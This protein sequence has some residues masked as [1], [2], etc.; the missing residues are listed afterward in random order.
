MAGSPSYGTRPLEKQSQMGI[1][2]AGSVNT[3]FRG[4]AD[5]LVKDTFKC[6]NSAT[7][8]FRSTF[9][10]NITELVEDQLLKSCR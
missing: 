1:T 10:L 4:P 8:I 5:C 6:F 2:V 9:W 7:P 3:V